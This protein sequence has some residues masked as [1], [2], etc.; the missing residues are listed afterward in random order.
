RA[1]SRRSRLS[2]TALDTVSG[3]TASGQRAAYCC[4]APARS[5]VRSAAKR[6]ALPKTR[7]LACAEKRI[8]LNHA[9]LRT[10]A[11]LTNLSDVHRSHLVRAVARPNNVLQQPQKTLSAFPSGDRCARHPTANLY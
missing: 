2:K 7:R 4:P 8:K 10:G 5:N 6:S 1:G 11:S 3:R 9:L